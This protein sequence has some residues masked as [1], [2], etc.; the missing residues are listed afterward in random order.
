MFAK[1][2]TIDNQQARD[3]FTEETVRKKL[4]TRLAAQKYLEQLLELVA[5]INRIVLDIFAAYKQYKVDKAVKAA[6]KKK[7]TTTSSS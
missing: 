2:K 6:T 1:P 7:D 4:P 3:A 5:K